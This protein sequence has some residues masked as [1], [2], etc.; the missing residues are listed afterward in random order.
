MGQSRCIFC[1]SGTEGQEQVCPVCKK[2]IWEYQWKEKYLEPYTV[3]HEKYL[4]GAVLQEREQSLC[5]M[6]YD[7]VLDQKVIIYA[8][9]SDLWETCKKKEAVLLFRRLSSSGMAA[10]KDYFFLDSAGY[11]ITSFAEGETLEQYLKIHGCTGEEQA[12]QMLLPVIRAV[13]GL[14]AEGQVHGNIRPE[15]LIVL[16]EGTLCLMADCRN[17]S[18]ENREDSCTAPEQRKEKGI[19]GPWTDVYAL[20]AVLYEMI[21]GR[22]P[23]P[24]YHR[25]KKDKLKKPSVYREISQKTERAILQAM[26]MDPQMRFFCLGNL[27]ECVSVQDHAVEQETGAV[28]HIWGEIWLEMAGSTEAE[29]KKGGIRG[30]LWKRLLAAAAAVICLAGMTAGGIWIYIETHQPEYFEWRLDK[31]RKE[32]DTQIHQGIFIKQDP[33]YEEVK[34]YILKYGENKEDEENTADRKNTYYTIEEKDLEQCPVSQSAS[35]SFYLD[36]RTA[37]KAVEYYMG[38]N[39][40]MDLSDTSFFGAGCIDNNE[41]AAIALFAE[42]TVTYSVRKSGEQAEFVYDPLSGR[43]L[44]VGYE[45]TKSRCADFLKEMTSLVAP[46]TYLTEDETEELM[47]TVPGE[48]DFHSL[49]LNAKYEIMMTH[50][51]DWEDGDQGIYSVGITPQTSSVKDWF[52]IYLKEDEDNVQYAGN[53]E[54]GSKRYEEFTDFVKENAVSCEKAEMEEDISMLDRQEADI[55]TLEEKDILEWG[56]PCNNFRF[57]M[58]EE[59]L[60]RRLRENGYEMKK[61][62]EDRENTVEIQKYGAILTDFYVVTE[63]HMKDH[64]YLKTARDLVNNDILTMMIYKKNGSSAPLHEMAAEVGKLLGDFGREDLKDVEE[65]LRKQ[66]EEA[67]KE[68]TTIL[69]SFGQTAYLF[70]WDEEQNTDAITEIYIVPT[71]KFDGASYYWP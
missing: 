34:A 19:Q 62:S 15:D 49:R 32:T 61:I 57:F 39:G 36:Y 66:H 37:R 70:S 35:E 44:S 47:E 26:A 11:M 3:L 68:K 10:V 71:E 4:V 50:E 9:E 24:V 40:N 55:Y 54:R 56:E 60:V 12:V 2:G 33:E 21:T 45:A 52:G 67:E 58:K 20:G 17:S 29:Q 14:H 41:E 7:Q 46:E 5:Y 53:Y 38:I 8:Y 63:Y 31:A 23:V 1:M 16:E 30:Y 43:L 48:E 22:K 65:E 51:N 69:H 28:R 13:N 25:L 27:L 42:K 59:D 18:G 6:G 64:I